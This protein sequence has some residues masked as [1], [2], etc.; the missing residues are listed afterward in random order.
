MD[1]RTTLSTYDFF[2]DA[3]VSHGFLPSN[4]DYQLVAEITGQDPVTKGSRHFLT[5]TFHFRGCV[6]A[7]YESVV[8]AFALT[9]AFGEMDDLFLDYDRWIAAGQPDGYVW[10]VNYALAY[11]GLTYM[12]D[13]DRARRW[14]EL[15]NIEMHEVRIKTNVYELSLVFR[16]VTVSETVTRD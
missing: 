11:P 3:I 2:D 16:D 1:V 7:H 4:R 6:E 15:L 8:P 14:T 12:D 9:E 5:Y 10:G 13:S